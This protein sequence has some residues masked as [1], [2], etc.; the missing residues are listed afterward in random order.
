MISKWSII[1][2]AGALGFAIITTFRYYLAYPDMDKFL[3]YITIAVLIAAVSWL[4]NQQMQ[5][6]YTLN[7]IE[8]YLDDKRINERGDE[9]YGR[10]NNSKRLT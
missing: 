3:A 4:F 1:G 5:H 10:R 9:E 8:D 2:Y 6:G 7:A